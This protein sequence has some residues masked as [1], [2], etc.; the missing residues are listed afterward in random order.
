MTTTDK[1]KKAAKRATREE[2]QELHYR[3]TK[4]FLQV[5]RD[6]VKHEPNANLLNCIR[7]F[8]RDNGCT[9]NTAWAKDM[10]EGLETLADS[11]LPFLPTLN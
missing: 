6:P 10:K 3:L 2:L 11:N 1:P 9:K 7:Q 5:L 8:L 4:L